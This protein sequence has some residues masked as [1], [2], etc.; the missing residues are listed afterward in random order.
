M[1]QNKLQALKLQ[2]IRDLAAEWGKAVAEQALSGA[3]SD[4]PMDFHAMEQIAAAAAAGLTQGTIAT[5]LEQ[6]AK[7]LNTMASKVRCRDQFSPA[8]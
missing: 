5:L 3:G 2:A 1:P 4:K 7:T 6:Q 8:A